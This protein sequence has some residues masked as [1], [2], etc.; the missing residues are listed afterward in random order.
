MQ[1]MKTLLAASALAIA[2]LQSS[3]ARATE[4]TQGQMHIPTRGE[5]CSGENW[6]ARCFKRAAKDDTRL[7]QCFAAA[8][9]EATDEHGLKINPGDTLIVTHIGAGKVDSYDGF[10]GLPRSAIKFLTACPMK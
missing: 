4:C 3:Q 8:I 10:S 7:V 9:G 1:T 5:I 6:A 2:I